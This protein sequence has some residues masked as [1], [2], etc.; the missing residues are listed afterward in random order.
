MIPELPAKGVTS[1]TP[2]PLHANLMTV[3]LTTAVVH[4]SLGDPVPWYEYPVDPGGLP[5]PFQR[6]AASVT[7][8]DGDA[9]PVSTICSCAP[10]TL[11]SPAGKLNGAP[12]GFATIFARVPG[13]TM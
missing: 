4:G 3:R 2:A 8:I 1:V 11:G 7:V 13:S 5:R 10:S 9:P 6:L 12:I